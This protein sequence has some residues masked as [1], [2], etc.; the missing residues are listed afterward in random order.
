MKSLA[1]TVVLL[2]ASCVSFSQ[3]EF[4]ERWEGNWKGDLLWY[5][6]FGKESRKVSME[7]N[8][9]RTDTAWSWQLVYGSPTEDN[10][11]YT[12]FPVDR[13]KGHW[14]I[15][16]HNGIVL[17]QFF[18]AGRLNGAF[19]VGSSTI[20][21][22]YELKGDSLIVEFSTLQAAPLATT[23]QG[24]EDSPKVDSYRV[25]GFQRAVLRR[26]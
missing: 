3:S 5:A 10:R 7:L 20:F 24:T 15:N 6:G 12:L 17:D 21:N 16:E 2:L 18:L 19:T 25:I 22:S 1:L 14:A 26:S 23:G 11:P 13:N 8:I 9:R 4:P